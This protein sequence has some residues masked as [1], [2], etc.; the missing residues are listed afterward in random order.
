MAD[1]K[2]DSDE[3]TGK[4]KLELSGIFCLLSVVGRRSNEETTPCGIPMRTTPPCRALRPDV[5]SSK[6]CGNGE[7]LQSECVMW[8]E[9]Y[10]SDGPRQHS[11]NGNEMLDFWSRQSSASTQGV[12]RGQLASRRSAVGHPLKSLTPAHNWPESEM[13]CELTSIRPNTGEIDGGAPSTCLYSHKSH[14]TR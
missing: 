13:S 14:R 12:K 11:T 4:P 10:S 9:A 6:S 5:A 7:A 8:A 1:P 2:K 3:K